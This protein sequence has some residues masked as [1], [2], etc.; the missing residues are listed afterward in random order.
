MIDLGNAESLGD[1]ARQFRARLGDG[2]YLAVVTIEIVAQVRYLAHIAYPGE[3]NTDR[4]HT[5]A[6]KA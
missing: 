4:I 3:R 5:F 2:R 1:F 6:P